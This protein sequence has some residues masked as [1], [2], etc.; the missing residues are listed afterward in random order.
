[1]EYR[2]KKLFSAFNYETH[3]KDLKNDLHG[4]VDGLPN[5]LIYSGETEDII[6][7]TKNKYPSKIPTIDH[8]FSTIKNRTDVPY[9]DGMLGNKLISGLEYNFIY[10]FSGS[11]EYFLIK[12]PRLEVHD[13]KA[14]VEKDRNT[15]C[16]SV[17][18]MDQEHDMIDEYRE[19]MLRRIMSCLDT[20]RSSQDIIIGEEYNTIRRRIDKWKQMLSESEEISKKFGYEVIARGD[21]PERFPLAVNAEAINV[22][23]ESEFRKSDK[24]YFLNE[25][26][27]KKIISIIRHTGVA[28]ERAPSVA[29]GADENFLRD[30]LLIP[31]NGML[32][33]KASGETFNRE[34]KT[35]IIIR[36]E[37]E[38]IFVAECKIWRGA[39]KLGD[40]IDQLFK[41]ITWRELKTAL[42]V[43]SQNKNFRSVVETADK[44][45]RKHKS[46]IMEN[47]AGIKGECEYI[48]RDPKRRHVEVLL[49]MLMCDVS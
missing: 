43:F 28:I 41:Y 16:I 38:N 42:I 6:E 46:F 24:K 40:A 11:G 17:A 10:K 9:N 34:G 12:P 33:G 20:I 21:I 32:K 47:N 25:E 1:M 22:D 31:L 35:D 37:D 30:V 36:I 7:L 39:K 29:R 19:T 44:A 23:I 26:G 15:I 14:D 5:E 2:G 45:V 18:V 13:V 3:I 27:Y 49:T 48:L 8:K 4:F